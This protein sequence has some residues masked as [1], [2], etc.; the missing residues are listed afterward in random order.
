[1]MPD[2]R[3]IEIQLPDDVGALLDRMCADAGR[4]AEDLCA[5]I[6]RDVVLDDAEH[7]QAPPLRRK[8]EKP[9]RPVT[10][11]VDPVPMPKEP[12]PAPSPVRAEPE[13]AGPRVWTKQEVASLKAYRAIGNNPATCA[14]LLNIPVEEVRAKL[15]EM[16]R[17]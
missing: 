3:R 15:D 16:R 5:A 9:A 2:V 10:K 12:E 6:V 14:G 4:P 1:M 8:R 13:P 17:T 7:H 11:P